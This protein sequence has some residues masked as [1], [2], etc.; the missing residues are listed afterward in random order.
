[1]WGGGPQEGPVSKKLAQADHAG[2]ESADKNETPFERCC[3]CG[4]EGEEVKRC[5]QCKATS[6]CSIGCQMS[7]RGYH[8]AYCSA[9]SALEQLER[10]KLYQ[11]FSVRQCQVDFRTKKKLI[12]LVGEKPVLSCNLG[13]KKTNVLWDTGSMVSLVDRRWVA[14]NFPHAK[15]LS[16][17]DFLDEKLEV[18][19][20]NS[21]SMEIDG[22]V[23]LDFSLG[24]GG[25]TVSV[26]FVVTAQTLI[27][28]ILGYNVIEHLVLEG[29]AD[30]RKQ[31]GESLGSKGKIVSVDA[32]A[33]VIEEKAVNRD[34]LT[35]VKSPRA[36]TV[37]PGCHVQVKCRVKAQSDDK[38]QSVYFEPL[39]SPD[40]CEDRLVC[41]ETVS[42][43]RR[44]HTNH[45]V[46]D[47]MNLSGET[48]VLKK[49]AVLGS[50]HSVS[51]VMPMKKLFNSGDEPS[52]KEEGGKVKMK[53]NGGGKK[54]NLSHLDEE[55][56]EKLEKVLLKF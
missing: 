38:E 53:T 37:A 21:T 27:E 6:Y 56:K 5:G 11:G 23:V 28:P 20:A 39:L 2:D 16:V 13:A 17:S 8:K 52:R 22:V 48:K 18:K 26:P 19:A 55:K 47:V 43:L 3:A 33:A 40:G 9:V 51:A 41:S 25:E 14:L 12:R 32:L 45:V 36:V 34:F 30:Q 44:G 4:F 46:V 1:M 10:E 24:D 7:H 54:W 35:E 49:G 31:L 29:D 50:V 15:I 42:K